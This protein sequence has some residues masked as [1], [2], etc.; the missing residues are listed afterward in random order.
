M[1][2]HHDLDAVFRRG[3]WHPVL[4]FNHAQGLCR[5]S[6]DDFEEVGRLLGVVRLFCKIL[7]AKPAK[8]FQ[9]IFVLTS[10]ILELLKGK[11]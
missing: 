5:G 3:A 11:L 8:P 9:Y 6:F 4:V 2:I 1:G 10:S 7:P